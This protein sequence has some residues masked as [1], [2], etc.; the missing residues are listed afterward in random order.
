MGIRLDGPTVEHFG[1]ADILSSGVIPGTIQVP[2]DG[3]PIIL[4]NDCQTTG[5]YTRIG[6]AVQEDLRLL[7]QLKPGD[8][9]RFRELSLQ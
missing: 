7:A 4:M 2:G 5:G 8:H 3:K 1:S 9:I 6:C